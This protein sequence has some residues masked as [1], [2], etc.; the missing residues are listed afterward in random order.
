MKRRSIR[1]VLRVVVLA[2]MVFGIV[3]GVRPAGA[4][5]RWY[6]SFPQAVFN[7]TSP[8]GLGNDTL[9][10]R[11][12]GYCGGPLVT[13][14]SVTGLCPRPT[15]NRI[16]ST[17]RGD[18][19]EVGN[20][21]HFGTCDPDPY[22]LFA[23]TFIFPV[24]QKL[25]AT[26]DVAVTIGTASPRTLRVVWDPRESLGNSESEFNGPFPGA[27]PHGALVIGPTNRTGSL[28]L[29]TRIGGRC[30]PQGNNIANYFAMSFWA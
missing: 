24:H 5:Q 17:L 6:C 11:G 21:L 30:P 26:I 14:C 8:P 23:P 10:I 13:T 25:T 1:T 4:V 16:E 28:Q 19:S 12:I 7:F 29:S 18:A 20:E 22:P 15:G 3:G 9:A 2:A 27:T